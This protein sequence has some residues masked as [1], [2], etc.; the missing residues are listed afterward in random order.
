[1]ATT[2]LIP[3]HMNKGRTMAKCLEDRLAYAVNG[4]KTENGKYVSSYE[5]DEHTADAEFMLQ[6]RMYHNQIAEIRS[7]EV[8]AYQIRQ[9]FKPGE[10]TPDK[11]NE[12]GY[13][14]AMRFTKGN[15]SFV[16]S[17]HTDKAHIHN[18]IIF[19]STTLDCSRKFKNF[20]Y[21]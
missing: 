6:K 19:N 20:F 4:E 21:S 17:T 5:C 10:I 11:A 7:N 9:S 18:H 16:V 3:L 12:I 2:R 1:M 15:Y 8:I 13:E 14:L